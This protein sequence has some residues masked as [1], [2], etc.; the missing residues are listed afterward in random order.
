MLGT[1]LFLCGYVG[2]SGEAMNPTHQKV[3]GKRCVEGQVVFGNRLILSIAELIIRLI[4][5]M[6][7]VN[8]KP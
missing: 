2:S 5:I 4:G 6:S 3:L 7:A 8:P 1:S